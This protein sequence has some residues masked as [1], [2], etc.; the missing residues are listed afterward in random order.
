MK[1]IRKIYEV[2][3]PTCFGILKNLFSRD[4]IRQLDLQ[5]LLIEVLQ[6]IEVDLTGVSL[7]HR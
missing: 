6:M 1:F 2:N 4:G 7:Q 5:D 3:I